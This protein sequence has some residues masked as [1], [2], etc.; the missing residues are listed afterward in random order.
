MLLDNKGLLHNHAYNTL[1]KESFNPAFAE[2]LFI[3]HLNTIL[4]APETSRLLFHVRTLRQG[5][6]SQ[7]S[8]GV[9]F[10][11][12]GLPPEGCLGFL[13]PVTK[14]VIEQKQI[15]PKERVGAVA[16]DTE[17]LRGRS[18]SAESIPGPSGPSHRTHMLCSK[19]DCF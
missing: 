7:S 13:F 16:A 15:R 1:L 4:E 9:L 5:D 10:L 12:Q 14:S 2:N 11:Y 19:G 3:C 6:D 18:W 17:P 8:S